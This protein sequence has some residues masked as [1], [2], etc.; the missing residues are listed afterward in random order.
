MEWK[1]IEERSNEADS[2]SRDIWYSEDG[3]D[4]GTKFTLESQ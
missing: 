4:I 1:D 3:T 2:L